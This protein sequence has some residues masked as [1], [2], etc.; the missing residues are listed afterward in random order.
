MEV[1]IDVDLGEIV[2]WV[3]QVESG[4]EEPYQLPR[5]LIV[6]WAKGRIQDGRVLLGRRYAGGYGEIGDEI[7][8]QSLVEPSLGFDGLARVRF[9]ASCN[10]QRRRGEGQSSRQEV[11]LWVSVKVCGSVRETKVAEGERQ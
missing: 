5:V 1:V 10:P 6:E 7:L 8:L 9:D 3:D 11:Q 2:V 4:D